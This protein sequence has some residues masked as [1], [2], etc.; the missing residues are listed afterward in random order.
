MD[1]DRDGVAVA[2]Q[3]LVDRVVNN[4]IDEVVQTARPGRADVHAGTFADC[5]ESLQD[6]DVLGVISCF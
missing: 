3:R 5:L 1:R 6:R 4:L 2:G